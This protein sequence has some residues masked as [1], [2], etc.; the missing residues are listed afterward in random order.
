MLNKN[1]ISKCNGINHKCNILH[2][3]VFWQMFAGRALRK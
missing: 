3:I 1:S 2:Q